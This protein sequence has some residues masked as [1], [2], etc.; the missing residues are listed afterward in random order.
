MTLRALLISAAILWALS[1]SAMAAGPGPGAAGLIQRIVGG[2]II[3][4]LSR[5]QDRKE[6]KIQPLP[7]P[8]SSLSRP[9]HA[10][11]L[12]PPIDQVGLGNRPYFRHSSAAEP[13]VVIAEVSRAPRLPVT[14]DKPRFPT[15]PTVLDE[16]LERPLVRPQSKANR[17]PLK[18]RVKAKALFCVDNSSNRVILAHNVNEPLPIASI[19]KLITAML[20]IDEMKLSRIVRVPDDIRKVPKHRVG[21]RR[22]DLL[23]VGDVLHGMLIESGND[24]AE[25]LARAYPKGGRKGFLVAMNRRAA[26]IGASKTKIMTPSG[27]DLMETLGRKNGRDLVSK[28]P[29]VASAQDVALI[30]R[31]A[32]RYPSI[33][34]ISSMKIHTI[35]T[36]N[37][38]PRKYILATNDKLLHR[39][40]PVAGAKTG[41]TNLAG[42]CIVALFK[43]DKRDYTVVVLNTNKHFKA[44]EKIYRWACK[45]F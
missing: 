4:P 34:K 22:G 19:T 10:I 27:L 11:P 8:G 6:Q 20:V 1:A 28:R 24:C 32:F 39:K 36:R 42:K 30:A 16:L 9:R 5:V 37:K 15:I 18:P 43:D 31:H 12:P 21:L 7:K 44:A 26:L 38:K 3:V 41:Y 35:R 2:E 23:S 45:T 14:T 25:V 17:A 29:N 13:A 33:R 40:L